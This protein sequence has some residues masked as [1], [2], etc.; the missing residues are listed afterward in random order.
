[1]T[2]SLTSTTPQPKSTKAHMVDGL[3]YT[4]SGADAEAFDIVPAT[5]QILTVEK[6]D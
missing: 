6:L 2:I 4:L 1:M 3:T 5:G